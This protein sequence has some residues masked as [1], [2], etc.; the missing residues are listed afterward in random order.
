[1]V[2]KQLFSLNHVPLPLVLKMWEMMQIREKFH[3]NISVEHLFH[4]MLA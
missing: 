4:Q 3:E 2:S 1:M